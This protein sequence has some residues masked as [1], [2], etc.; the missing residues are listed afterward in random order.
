MPRGIPNNGINKGW[1]KKNQ[2]PKNKGNRK[3]MFNCLYCGKTINTSDNRNIFCSKRCVMKHVWIN[4]DMSNSINA[5]L[6][7]GKS[8]RFKNGEHHSLKTEYKYN[9]T[10]I[11]G[12]NN[13]NWKG[14]ITPLNKKIRKCQKWKKWRLQVFERDNYTCQYCKLKGVFLHPHHLKP[15]FMCIDTLDLESIFDVNNGLTLCVEC[16]K[17]VHRGK[18]E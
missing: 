2:A 7:Y 10:R 8:Y 12:K 4:K 9:D 14:G 1:F 13:H 11:T 16:H 3:Y 18:R 6:K 5:L 15:V 17:N